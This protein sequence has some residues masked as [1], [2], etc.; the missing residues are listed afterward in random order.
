VSK[1]PGVPPTSLAFVIAAAGRRAQRE[2]DEAVRDL[3]L[4]MRHLGA[5]GHLARNEDLSAS[6]LA[7][8]SKITAQSMHVTIGELVDRGAL[9]RDSSGRGRRAK[10]QVTAVGQRLLQ[11]GMAAVAGV[12]AS[13]EAELGDLGPAQQEALARYGLQGPPPSTQT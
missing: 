1:G 8:R 3:G 6:D 9:R 13:I 7:R 5:L 12:D 10:L 2:M 11:Q 4:S